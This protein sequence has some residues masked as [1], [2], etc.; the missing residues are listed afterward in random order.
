MAD[1]LNPTAE[2]V[3]TNSP[4][5]YPGNQFSALPSSTIS[6]AHPR[7]LVGAL[8]IGRVAAKPQAQLASAPEGSVK[9]GLSLGGVGKCQFFA[10][11]RVL[12]CEASYRKRPYV[13]D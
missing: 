13:I 9:L 10:N 11:E 1:R 8:V 3:E 7:R 4:G 6:P 12:A 2:R 5:R